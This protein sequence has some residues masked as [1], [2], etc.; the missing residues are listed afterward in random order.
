MLVQNTA[1]WDLSR[2]ASHVTLKCAMPTYEITGTGANGRGDTLRLHAERKAD[3]IAEAQ[4][5][6]MRIAG[7]QE[8]PP[9]RPV[10]GSEQATR[11]LAAIETIARSKLVR[12]P[13]RTI[14][15]G[16]VLASLA[17]FM[18]IWAAWFV[19]TAMHTGLR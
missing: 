16:I 9:D 10:S 5:L 13:V 15:G 12:K 3:A 18:V 14:C 11:H 6:G 17:I 4:K 19:F 1:L 2:G 8:L 7:V